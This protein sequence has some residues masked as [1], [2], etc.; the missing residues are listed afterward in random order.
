MDLAWMA[1]HTVRTDFILVGLFGQSNH[2][3]LLCTA[4][5]VAF[6][7]ALSGNAVLILLIHVD[8]RL[9]TPMYFF[10]GQLSLLD[11]MYISVTVPKMLLN[12]VMGVKLI[13]APECGV[14]MFLYLTL[15]G[16]EFFLLA[17]MSY[18][19]YVAICRPLRYPVLMNHRVCVLL[20]AGCW[21]LGSVDGFMLTP[22]TMAFP[23]CRSREIPHFFCEVP[24][25]TRLSCSDTSLYKTL[26]YLCCV[27]M[28]LLP[29]TVISASY[30]SILLTVHRMS[31]AEG[32][33]KA[34][35][36]CSSHMTVVILF[37]GAAVYTYM[38]PSSYH[39]PKK[40][41]LVSVFYTILTPVLNPLIYSLR[42]KD[43]TGALKKTFRV[44]PA[45]Q[46]PIFL[47]RVAAGSPG[48]PPVQTASVSS[49][50][51]A[52]RAAMVD[53]PSSD[54]CGTAKNRPSKKET[55]PGRHPTC[56]RR[57]TPKA[58]GGRP[59]SRPSGLASCLLLLGS[60]GGSL[61]WL[62]S[63]SERY[64]PDA[65]YSFGSRLSG[66]TLRLQLPAAQAAHS[67]SQVSSLP[68]ASFQILALSSLFKPSD[69]PQD[70]REQKGKKTKR[71]HIRTAERGGARGKGTGKP[72]QRPREMHHGKGEADPHSTEGFHA[73]QWPEATSRQKPWRDV[74]SQG[75]APAAL[76]LRRSS[77]SSHGLGP[78]LPFP[79]SP[80]ARGAG[81]RLCPLSR[82]WLIAGDRDEHLA[83]SGSPSLPPGF[84][85]RMFP[86]RRRSRFPAHVLWLFSGRQERSVSARLLG[87]TLATSQLA[88]CLWHPARHLP[89]QGHRRPGRRARAARRRP[90]DSALSRP[91]SPMAFAPLCPRGRSP[92][93][94]CRAPGICRAL[95]Q[96]QGFRSPPDL[97]RELRSARASRRTLPSRRLESLAASAASAPAGRPLRRAPPVAWLRAAAPPWSPQGGRVPPRLSAEG[98]ALRNVGGLLNR[99]CGNMEETNSSS[100]KGFLLLGFSGQ[101]QLERVLFVVILHL[102]VLSLLGN[103]A[104]LLVSRLDPKLRTPMYFLLSNLSCVDICFTTSVAPQLLAT[105]SRKDKSMSYGGC[106]AQLYVAMGLG[107]AE[108]IL[109]AVMAYDRYAAVCRP[110]HYTAIMHPRLCGSLASSAW[111]SGLVTSLIQCSLTVRLPL[112][113]HRRLDHI[114]CEVPVLIKLA[115]VDTTF[116]EAELFVASVVFL[117]VPVSL[118][119][120]SYGF[121][122]R[123]VLR[124][125]SATGRRKAFGTCSSHLLVVAIFYG[126]IIFMYLQPA[127]SHSK[128]QGKFVSLFYTIVTPLLNPVIYTLRNKDVNSALKALVMRGAPGLTKA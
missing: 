128:N 67:S 25:V 71:Y 99:R 26:M 41:M 94:P 23:F 40:D 19:R 83:R 111:L 72:G 126:T 32:R 64:C 125:R 87:E 9:H 73:V 10:I 104:I 82:A 66:L 117:V 113:G 44:R 12:Q 90:A 76:R 105:M 85:L 107:S 37:Y 78:P 63:P 86:P 124:I 122:A 48:P 88:G 5:F 118:I 14:Q 49:P 110:L 115:C 29:V 59:G 30:A 56:V 60:P 89:S 6:S 100:E 47:S 51:P 91:P 27:L 34:L 93:H 112:C 21:L 123:A 7:M 75:P 33:K 13:S 80:C 1:N 17:A 61:R 52:V 116:N 2:P 92:A 55:L 84:P 98:A 65:V 3:A 18:D 46:A 28:L 42:N 58:S 69:V 106:V 68:E 103:A 20:A 50:S 35:A 127:K 4:I 114:F 102:Y 43:V 81:S 97:R 119:L 120:V 109:L 16:S 108:C 8:T 62:A 79:V 45:P 22:V 54:P 31:S 95:P 24:A 36:T 38:L 74:S 77:S 11:M 15:V 96:W 39:T 53:S 121:I 70:I 101:P 57:G